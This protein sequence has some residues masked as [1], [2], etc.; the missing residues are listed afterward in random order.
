MVITSMRYD[1]VMISN[2]EI[3][4][5]LSKIPRGTDSEEWRQ[6]AACLTGMRDGLSAKQ[7]SAYHNVPID[8]VNNYYSTSNFQT[9]KEG[10]GSRKRKSSD[11]ITFIKNNIGREIT[12]TEFAEE[13]GISL[14]TF[15]NYFNANRGWFKKVKRGL[16]EIVD[17]DSARQS[18]K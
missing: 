12:P 1:F 2:Q 14:P 10:K 6:I 18:E 16:F 5:R 13:V 8:F 9:Q 3:T 17:A 7:V 15:Y 11:I 4:E